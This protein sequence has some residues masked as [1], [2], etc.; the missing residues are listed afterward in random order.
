LSTVRP[1]I[2]RTARPGLRVRGWI[3]LGLMVLLMVAVGGY[4]YGKSSSFASQ[5]NLNSLLLAAMPLAFV[6]LAQAS[7]LLIGGF[8]ISVGPS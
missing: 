7:V 4:A 2:L 3:P 5:F 1:A 6:A 8:D